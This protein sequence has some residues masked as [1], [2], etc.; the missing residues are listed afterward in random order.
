MILLDTNAFLWYLSDKTKFSDSTLVAI[1]KERHQSKP[2]LVSAISIWEV[3]LLIQKKRIQLHVDYDTWFN[4]VR[5]LKSIQYV[6]ITIE[7]SH[8]SIMLPGIFHSDP[9]DRIIV[10][11]S[12]FL[13]ATLITSDHLIRKYKHVKT[14]W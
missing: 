10:A 7:I 14:I 11:T 6:P 2:L 13:G 8:E 3:G 12:R 1:Q 9:A 4:Q 5:K